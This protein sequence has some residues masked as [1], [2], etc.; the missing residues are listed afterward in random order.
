MAMS[1]A[2]VNCSKDLGPVHH[3]QAHAEACTKDS[4]HMQV[5]FFLKQIS[6]EEVDEKYANVMRQRHMF[7]YSKE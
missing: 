2:R 7:V 6:P 1:L 3:A 4:C 5:V